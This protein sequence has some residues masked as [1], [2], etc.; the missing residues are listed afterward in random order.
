MEPLCYIYAGCILVQGP[1]QGSVSYA[2]IAFLASNQ[3]EADGWALQCARE[4]WPVEEGFFDYRVGVARIE[5]S[6]L[7]ADSRCQGVWDEAEASP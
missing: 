2:Q 3:A 5:T 6:M 4:R 1:R 7:K